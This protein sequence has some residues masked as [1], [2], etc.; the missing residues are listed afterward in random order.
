MTGYNPL[1]SAS[2][3]HIYVIYSFHCGFCLPTLYATHQRIIAE[4][5]RY[6]QKAVSQAS[7]IVLQAIDNFLGRGESE[8]V[9]ILDGTAFSETALLARSS[10]IDEIPILHRLLLFLHKVILGVYFGVDSPFALK[11]L[12]KIS[13]AKMK[14]QGFLTVPWSMYVALAALRLVKAGH[15]FGKHKHLRKARDIMK[16]LA[17]AV[18]QGDVNAHVMHKLVLADYAV[19]KKE[20]HESVKEKFDAS[21]ALSR[22]SGFVNIAGLGNSLMAEY[23]LSMMDRDWSDFYGRQAIRMYQQWNSA[24][25]VRHM[26]T[27]CGLKTEKRYSLP[28][29]QQA[30]SLELTSDGATS[31]RILHSANFSDA[32]YGRSLRRISVGA[33]SSIVAGRKS[34]DLSTYKG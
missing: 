22:R 12:Y 31:N 14:G 28:D 16:E 29:Q 25:L 17:T 20:P 27:K 9:T 2:A 21:I 32:H 1:Q 19:A 10:S 23:F 18:K 7:H 5:E 34:G 4:M 3:G 26:E 33:G 8:D 30:S 24:M 11:E 6:E 15:S 13:N